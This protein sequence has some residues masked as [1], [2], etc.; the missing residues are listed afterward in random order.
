MHNEVLKFIFRHHSTLP[1]SVV[2]IG[3]KNINGSVRVFYPSANYHGIDLCAGR[4]VDEV[5]DGVTWQ[6]K[7]PVDLV[8][9]CEVLEHCEKW[10]EM[11]SNVSKML[12]PNGIFL[13]TA[14]YGSRAPHSAVDGGRVREGEYYSNI[15]AIELDGA[16]MCSGFSDLE[17]VTNGEHGDIYWKATKI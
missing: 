4:D 16:L 15:P 6:P 14:A 13:G 5:A 1:I 10:I 2:E 9:C 3:S 7:E 17:I 11:I 12:K 8:I